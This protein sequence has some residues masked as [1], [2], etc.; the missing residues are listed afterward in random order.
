MDFKGA[1]D[2]IVVVGKTHPE[3]AGSE[4]FEELGLKGT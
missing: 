1:H 4:Y 2:L 3:L